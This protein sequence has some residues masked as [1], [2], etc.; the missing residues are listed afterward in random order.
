MSKKLYTTEKWKDYLTRRQRRQDAKLRTDHRI[1]PASYRR[2]V[3]VVAPSDFS[4]VHNP[5]QSIAFLHTISAYSKKA[6]INLN[7]GG[8]TNITT[9]AIAALLATIQASEGAK[10]RGNH[11]ADDNARDILLQ[12]GFFDHVHPTVQLPPCSQGKISQRKSDIVE[13]MT[14][15]DLIHFGMKAIY[16]DD[17]QRSFPAYRVLIESMANTRNHAA[18]DQQQRQKW[19]ATVYADTGRKTVCFS[20]LDAGVG[21][22][23][24]VQIK[25]FR[26]MARDLRIKDDTGILEDILKGKVGSRTD[27]TYRGKGLPAIYAHEQAKRIKSLVI[28]ANDVHA[29]VS[30]DEYTLL[31]NAF[32]GTLIYFEI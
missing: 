21:I 19:W 25:G 14:A 26:R 11:P 20:F 31:D 18:S 1:L 23:R 12:S 17:K 6:H 2:F 16:G 24:S 29:N 32:S 13:P 27:L 10:T 22:F 15:R 8:I 30:K 5:E 3:T 28:V 7:L 9:D 4:I